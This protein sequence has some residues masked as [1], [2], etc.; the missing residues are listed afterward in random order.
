MLRRVKIGLKNATDS[1]KT[2]WLFWQALL[3][4]VL[5]TSVPDNKYDILNCIILEDWSS[6]CSKYFVR[7]G[8]SI[9]KANKFLALVW[10]RPDDVDASDKSA[11]LYLWQQLCSFSPQLIDN[12][13]T[14][15]EAT[16]LDTLLIH[17]MEKPD[18][19]KPYLKLPGTYRL[20]KRVIFDKAGSSEDLQ[21]KWDELRSHGLSY[22][23]T[24]AQ[25]KE[26]KPSLNDVVLCVVLKSSN[27][28][29]L[30]SRVNNPSFY[31]SLFN[32]MQKL[33]ELEYLLENSLDILRNE[34]HNNPDWRNQY[35]QAI[36][37]FGFFQEMERSSSLAVIEC[38]ATLVPSV[39]TMSAFL[40]QKEKFNAPIV[41][42]VLSNFEQLVDGD[43]E[44]TQIK[45]SDV[46]EFY[47]D[48]PDES[49]LENY[50][51][52]LYR[53][54]INPLRCEDFILKA[55]Q[56]I[57][58]SQSSKAGRVISWIVAFCFLFHE[59][60][61]RDILP[62]LRNNFF[63]NFNE[64]N[65]TTMERDMSQSKIDTLTADD[66]FCSNSYEEGPLL[67]QPKIAYIFLSLIVCPK[68]S[69]LNLLPISFLSPAQKEVTLRFLF[70]A[71]NPKLFI[72][73][74]LKNEAYSLI[75][76]RIVGFDNDDSGWEKFLVVFLKELEALSSPISQDF[77]FVTAMLEALVK[78][79]LLRSHNK[80]CEVIEDIFSNMIELLG[81]ASR[82]ILSC[83]RNFRGADIIEAINEG[84]VSQ[85]MVGVWSR[86]CRLF[87]LSNWDS[88]KKFKIFLELNIISAETK[89]F[90]EEGHSTQW[91]DFSSQVDFYKLLPQ[92]VKG[93]LLRIL[94]LSTVEGAA[95]T[96]SYSDCMK[97]LINCVSRGSDDVAVMM[98]PVIAEC[99]NS[100]KLEIVIKRLDDLSGE[101]SSGSLFVKFV[102]EVSSKLRDES[103]LSYMTFFC[104]VTMSITNLTSIG[105]QSASTSASKNA[106]LTTWLKLMLDAVVAYASTNAVEVTSFLVS[107]PK[108][109]L[110]YNEFWSDLYSELSKVH[111]MPHLLLSAL[112]SDPSL[113]P[114]VLS[115]Q[116]CVDAL[117]FK[118]PPRYIT[119]ILLQCEHQAI[120]HSF[121]EQVVF[122]N[123]KL[124]VRMTVLIAHHLLSVTFSK[125]R[126]FA[127]EK[128]LEFLQEAFAKARKSDIWTG[129]CCEASGIVNRK[130]AL[131]K[132]FA[133]YSRPPIAF[134]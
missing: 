31:W 107:L 45:I 129:V 52:G 113:M 55:F 22:L 119:D 23:A 81:P 47:V 101:A 59:E 132:V 42:Q 128:H 49:K 89:K 71:E 61:S 65:T 14:A 79:Q 70:D 90:I 83:T 131:S 99:L 40:S 2:R 95:D 51:L 66:V 32:Q 106:V 17:V 74:A 111:L 110:H 122:K 127:L 6:L 82:H 54:S 8:S 56:F 102:N 58:R 33:D 133:H 26:I 108:T 25:N 105:F 48:L 64:P 36:Q 103:C 96:D 77:K 19:V 16:L 39:R 67:L 11:C 75:N 120:L 97:D 7:S 34:L 115:H 46:F 76:D 109:G 73:S 28:S 112:T 27:F 134:E 78:M 57:Q 85:E 93:E 3:S 63:K 69:V 43:T 12:V 18:L 62:S 60:L 53:K 125:T 68:S 13:V 4:Q 118:L 121:L 29:S 10:S 41:S 116:E 72:S 44:R 50:F 35:R 80:N 104:R 38:M 1:N 98:L 91:T 88:S 5:K 24:I 100:K 84:G 130:K 37:G 30:I 21:R 86:L 87:A 20:I 117:T 15:N 114:S 124:V 126:R 9:L 94:D 92:M 123:E